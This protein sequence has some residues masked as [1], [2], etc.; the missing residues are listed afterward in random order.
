[1]S[2]RSTG[3]TKGG[4]A[5][6]SGAREHI[7]PERRINLAA[8]PTEPNSNIPWPKASAVYRRWGP[9]HEGPPLPSQCPMSNGNPPLY[10]ER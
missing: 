9:S 10:Q 7:P 1:M 2:E 4:A 3:Q 8:R 6:E 5:A